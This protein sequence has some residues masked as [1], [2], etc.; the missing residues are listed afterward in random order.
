MHQHPQLRPV[1]TLAVG[2]VVFGGALAVLVRSGPLDPRV[3]LAGVLAAAALTVA[4]MAMIWARRRT[5]SGRSG[6]LARRADPGSSPDGS[7]IRVA[8]IDLGQGQT[9]V[10]FDEPAIGPAPRRAGSRPPLPPAHEVTATTDAICAAV[11][12][13][14]ESAGTADAPAPPSGANP[15]PG[16]GLWARLVSRRP[17]PRDSR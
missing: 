2:T 11:V 4:L 16:A 5:E 9:A 17:P 6:A 3:A 10:I 13:A 1:A 12:A 15:S 14:V 7:E 8:I